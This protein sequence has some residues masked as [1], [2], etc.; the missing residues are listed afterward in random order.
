MTAMSVR[1]ALGSS[2]IVGLG[3]FGKAYDRTRHNI[4]FAAVDL[5]AAKHGLTFK[6]QSQFR[7]LVTQGKIGADSFFY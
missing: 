2:L 3:N 5:F 4:G 7:G 6:E 1:G